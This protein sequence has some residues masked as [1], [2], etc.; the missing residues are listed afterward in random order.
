M[1]DKTLNPTRLDDLIPVSEFNKHYSFP[2]IGAIRQLIF[3][4]TDDFN[5]KV[6]RK[7]SKRLYIKV[8]ALE[9]WIDETN[10]GQV[11]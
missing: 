4:N 11:A 3:K 8:S 10:G 1:T 5:T 6:I 7:I 9:Q 2:T